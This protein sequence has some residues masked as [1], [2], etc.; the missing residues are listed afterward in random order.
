MHAT[1][2]A[3]ECQAGQWDQC[4]M[5]LQQTLQWDPVLDLQRDFQRLQ[6]QMTDGIYEQGREMS[7]KPGEYPQK[8]ESWSGRSPGLH[9]KIPT[10]A[11]EDHEVCIRGSR[12]LHPEDHEV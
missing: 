7:A 2:A 6:P 10:P 12:R 3:A 8:K 1:K 11:S 4:S 5:D 9:P